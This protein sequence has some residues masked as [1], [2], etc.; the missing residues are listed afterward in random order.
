MFQYSALLVVLK[1]GPKA[2][3]T[4]CGCDDATIFHNDIRP[5]IALQ[6]RPTAT[7][8][9]DGKLYRFII[10]RNAVSS[11]GVLKRTKR[12]DG[13]KHVNRQAALIAAAVGVLGELHA[14]LLSDKDV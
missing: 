6:L 11:S 9:L 1:L 8:I 13:R 5:A 4:S 14:I 12:I 7:V 2:T 10:Q 3:R